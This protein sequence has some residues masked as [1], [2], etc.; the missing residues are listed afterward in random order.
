MKMGI[1]K[2]DGSSI[3]DSRKKKSSSETNLEQMAEHVEPNTPA[4]SPALTVK[5]L[6]IMETPQGVGI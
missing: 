2:T 5:I 1:E 6:P 4:A 3:K